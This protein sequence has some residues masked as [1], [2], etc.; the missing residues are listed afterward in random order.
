MC[1]FVYRN[2]IQQTEIAKSWLEHPLTTILLF[3]S[4]KDCDTI[5]SK[6]A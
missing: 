3:T 1:I 2:I 6:I 5:A 4:H